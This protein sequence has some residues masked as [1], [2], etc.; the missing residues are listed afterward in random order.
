M[1][2]SKE[3]IDFVEKHAGEDPAKLRLRFHGDSRLWLPLAINNIAALRK[4]RKFRLNDGADLTPR[5][6]PLEVSAQ[7]A[8]S[9]QVALLHANLAK[10]AMSVLDMTFGLGMDARLLAMNP[11]RRILGF[12]LREELVAAAKV[13]FA[14]FPNVEVRRGD[15]VRFLEEYEGEAFDL[16]FIDPAR[17]G[18]E[19]ERLYNLHDCQPDLIENLPLIRRNSR[20][21]MAKLSPM[22]DVTQTIR[23]LPGIREL[24]VVEEGNECKEL[25]AIVD[26]GIKTSGST[27]EGNI[28][29]K[30]ESSDSEKKEGDSIPDLEENAGPL[31]AI[32]RLSKG[33]LTNFSFRPSEERECGPTP[34]L[35]RLP[36]K[37]EFLLEPSAATMKAAPF[38]L[39]AK[40]FGTPFL[41]PN[42]HLYVSPAGEDGK[43]PSGMENFPGTVY[44][45]EQA[46]PLT[47]SNLKLLGRT[48]GRADIA[49]R[50]LKGFTPD[51]LRKRMKTKPGGESKI[52]AVTVA[53][54]GGASL[55]SPSDSGHIAGET[56]ALLVVSPAGE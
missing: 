51:S 34:P 40:R 3:Y 31:I 54:N 13:N 16:I 35:G 18:L 19:G 1:E 10:D 52:Y 29:D 30:W 7:Q 43:M 4:S 50:N 6:I 22:L 39:L 47:S 37:G 45:I 55:G 21:L 24:H 25:L 38:N 27:Y 32:D 12:D 11:L 20:R 46:L 28:S 33:K 2:F 15:S 42:T 5:V 23:D 36:R 44:R 9:A 53:T 56:P 41:H 8:T 17:R 49:V 48:V 26:G 14:E